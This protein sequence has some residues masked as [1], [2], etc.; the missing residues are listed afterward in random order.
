MGIFFIR[1]YF[2]SFSVSNRLLMWI[3]LLEMIDF[4]IFR[5][6]WGCRLVLYV[7]YWVFDRSF[8]WILLL[9]MWRWVKFG[10]FVIFG[11]ILVGLIL[12]ICSLWLSKVR[13]EF[14]GVF[15]ILMNWLF[16]WIGSFDYL[17]VFFILMKVCEGIFLGSLSGGILFG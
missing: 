8:L 1:F 3:V 10:C 16:G 15:L 6:W 13:Y 12:M 17:S 11:F 7:S 5:V 4:I 9:C 2:G 14:F